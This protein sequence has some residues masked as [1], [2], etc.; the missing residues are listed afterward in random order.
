[1]IGDRRPY[2]VA[3]LTLDPG[4]LRR[5]ARDR[6]IL[7]TDPELLLHHPEIV[8]R[9]DRAVAAINARLQSYARVKRFA[10]LPGEL[11]EDAGELTPTQKVRRRYVA[12]KYCAQIDALYRAVPADGGGSA[13]VR[14]A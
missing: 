9:V 1:M 12:D 6:G 4:E 14:I 7:V 2:P 10:I 3:L 11:T 8:A 13:D 5:F